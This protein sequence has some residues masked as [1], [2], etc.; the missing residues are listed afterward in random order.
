LGG[1]E[2]HLD[3]TVVIGQGVFSSPGLLATVI[4]HEA[5]HAQQ[6]ADDRWFLEH[7]EQGFYMNE[8]EAYAWNL[9]HAGE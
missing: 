2:T 6:I 9:E 8:V 3:G 1:A 7:E 5:F 4:A